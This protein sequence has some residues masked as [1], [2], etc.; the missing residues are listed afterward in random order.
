[1]RVTAAVCLHDGAAFIGEA[2]SSVLAQTCGDFEIVLVDDGSTDGAAEFL[3]AWIRDPRLKIVRAPHRGLGAARAL[4]VERAAGEWIAFLDQDDAWM[5]GKL[6]RFLESAAS[7]PEAGLI[8]SDVRFVNEAGS[9]IGALSA[10]FD[11][12]T[13]D[14]AP[15]AAEAELLRRGNFIDASAAMVR[16][17]DVRETGNFDPRYRYVEDLDQWLRIARRRRLLA[18]PEALSVR[19]IHAG[20]FTQ[21]YPETALAEQMA[22][23]RPRTTDLSLPADV[24][25]AVGDYLLGQHYECARRLL[26]RRRPAASVRVALGAFRF[27]DRIMDA[28]HF[29][30]LRRGTPKAVRGAALG[31]L[32]VLVRGLHKGTS[33]L[34]ALRGR[35]RRPVHV[36]VDGTPLD[37]DRTGYFTFVTELV[38]SLLVGGPGAPVVHVSATAAGRAA[39]REVLGPSFAR[40]SPRRIRAE[41]WHWSVFYD[42]AARPEFQALVALG[43]AGLLLAGLL[44]PLP[45]L[46]LAGGGLVLLQSLFLADRLRS[47]FVRLRGDSDR[48]PLFQKAVLRVHNRIWAPR[49]RSGQKS[50]VEIVT[51]RGR[52]RF[53]DSRRL[54]YVPDLTTRIGPEWH[55]AANV[56]EFD[57]YLRYA[58]H[59]AGTLATVS[60]HSR[61][62]IVERLGW[63]LERVS[64]AP[65][66]VNP[67]FFAGVYP[68]AVPAAYGLTP[69]Y[70]LSVSTVEPRKNLRRLVRAFELLAE[71]RRG[72]LALVLAGPRGWDKGFDRFLAESDAYPGILRLGF[73]PLDRLPSLY[74]HAAAFIYPSLYEGFG[75]PVLEA[76]AAEAVVAAARTSSLPEVLGGE[77]IYFDPYD[78]EDI[79]AALR[80]ALA[81]RPADKAAY[82]AY[83]R[84]RAASMTEEWR[85]R[86]PW[87]L[88]PDETGPPSKA[89]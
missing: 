86:G 68:P 84:R 81:L 58:A 7:C 42:A 72:G 39:L 34:E 48:P 40:L 82:R 66:F 23:L 33:C 19:R 36:H 60:E 51:W 45:R 1:M 11:F 80:R 18:V 65:S 4:A 37:G 89:G 54:A 29:R 17:E 49:R 67:A 46:A 55:T 5:P 76:M 70:L 28:V 41:A 77:G 32:S 53:R 10:R 6:E 87:P 38:R 21:T 26:G 78:I 8:F 44:G 31:A 9:P 69:G 25:I 61:S 74:H 3:E 88:R 14:L 15:G 56:R 62:D 57:E 12:R 63:P 85:R 30:L 50:V 64:I 13:L 59:Y 24:R 43:A 73:V 27:P 83:A 71:E 16:R 79:A 75:L 22:L 47:E 52:F 2:L 20:Q 35:P